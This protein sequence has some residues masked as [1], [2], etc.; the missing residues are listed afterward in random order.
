MGKKIITFRPFGVTPSHE[1]CMF[2]AGIHWL[3]VKLLV[4]LSISE[5]KVP[6]CIPLALP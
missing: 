1:C 2:L 6:V 5:P 4:V 3:F